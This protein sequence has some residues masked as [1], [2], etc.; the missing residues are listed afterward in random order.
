MYLSGRDRTSRPSKINPFRIMLWIVLILAVLSLLRSYETGA[1]KP[2]FMPTPTPTRTTN[3]YALEGEAHFVAGDLEKAISAYQQATREDPNNA[4]LWAE[5]ARIETYS[6]NLLT[7]SEDQRVRLQDAMA[8]VDQAKKVAPDD[9]MV[10]ATRAFVL[11]W[12]ANPVLN[13]DTSTDLLN[14]AK[15]EA[16]AAIQID[17]TNTLALAYYAEIL[18]DQQQ[19]TQAA[20][21]IQQAMQR[22]DADGLMDVHRIQAFVYE[23]YGNYNLAI[24]EYEKAAQIAPNL[25]FL[26]IRIGVIYRHLQ[27]Y[28]KALET[29]QIAAR[30]N[31]QLGITDPTPYMALANTY[32]QMGQFLAAA[33]N[34]R[35]AL[36]L[37]PTT[38]AVYAQ[39]GIVYFHSRNYEGAIPAFECALQGCTPEKSCEVRQCDAATEA[40]ITIKGMPLDSETAVY[41]YTYGSVLS[42]LHVA[43]Q[44]DYCI[45]ALDILGQV[46]AKFASDQT[47]MGIVKAG[48]DICS[49]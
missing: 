41:Y 18:T 21:Y 4:Q 30:R 11:D 33:L 5:L 2:F 45:R 20:Q 39:L 48:E 12:A 9:S 26:Y 47:I 25:T 27:L 38:P 35:K 42:G 6:S 36:D 46:G 29:F 22:Q 44:D 1:I 49:N 31:D 16:V 23:T 19:L 40:P 10:R 32:V 3:S 37:N 13:P 8:S 43:G 17:Q 14:E 28:D 15:K 34:V 7:T 24:Q